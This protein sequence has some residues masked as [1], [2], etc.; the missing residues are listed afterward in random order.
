MLL[1]PAIS[2][3]ALSVMHERIKKVCRII[4]EK[5]IELDIDGQ[6]EEIIILMLYFKKLPELFGVFYVDFP[7]SIEVKI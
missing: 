6:K 5:L 4:I 1:P 3:T 7:V 2:L